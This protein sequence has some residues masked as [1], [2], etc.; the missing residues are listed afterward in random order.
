MGKI[1]LMDATGHV[2][3]EWSDNSI[4]IDLK[5]SEGKANK[6]ERAAISQMIKDGID[7]GMAVFIDR[8][9]CKRDFEEVGRKAQKIRMELTPV[10][11]KALLEGL[12]KSK[13]FSNQ[14]VFQIENG[15]GKLT[16][17]TVSE[18][19]V[20]PTDKKDYKAAKPLRGG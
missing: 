8:K 9:P 13:V 12:F 17:K 3:I 15:A 4:N 18:F 20:D 10:N 7:K 2:E 6:D 16:Q 5:P 1:A 11:V 14:L 19:N